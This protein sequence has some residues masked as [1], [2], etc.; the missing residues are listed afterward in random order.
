MPEASD[1]QVVEDLE[2][3]FEMHP[4]AQFSQVGVGKN[5]VQAELEDLIII[6][7]PLPEPDKEENKLEEMEMEIKRLHQV[8]LNLCLKL[9]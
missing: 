7:K 1:L 4:N 5:P 2:K 9:S 6:D 3:H 8:I